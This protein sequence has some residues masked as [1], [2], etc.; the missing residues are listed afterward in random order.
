M[1]CT[2]A[3]G[4]GVAVPAA[5]SGQT[6]L[7]LT[8]VLA[9][10]REQAPQVVS[11]RL[12]LE[13]ARGR[14]TGASLPAVES[15]DRRQRWQPAGQQPAI[16]RPPPRCHADVRAVRSP[17]GPHRRRHCPTGSGRCHGRGNDARRSP[18]GCHVVLPGALCRRAD[19][20]PRRI[21]GAGR[22]HLPDGGST[23]SRW[24]ASRS[25][26]Q[27]RPLVARPRARR[28]RSR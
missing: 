9:R 25:R 21:R 14:V 8:D 24:R 7:T 5:A 17:G 1:F 18:R 10:A 27:P 19:T 3:C 20:T 15:G 23:P 13:E 26:R 22:R 12:A 16:D 28:P 6:V 11:A 2:R 4:R